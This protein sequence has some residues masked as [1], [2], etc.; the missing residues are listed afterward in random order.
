MGTSKVCYYL[1]NGLALSTNFGLP[2]VSHVHVVTFDASLSYFGVIRCTCDF[3]ENSI[4]TVALH[5]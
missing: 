5:L 2:G 1:E 3:L 4:S